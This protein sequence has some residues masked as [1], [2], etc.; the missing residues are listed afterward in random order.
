MLMR[1]E[2][3]PGERRRKGMSGNRGCCLVWNVGGLV[4][5][6]HR[7][8]YRRIKRLCCSWGELNMWTGVGLQ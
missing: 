6:V 8:G 5:G 1:D 2:I 3:S 7:G 4:A